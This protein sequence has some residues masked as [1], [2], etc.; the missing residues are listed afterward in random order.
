MCPGHKDEPR[1]Q[2]APCN[3]RGGGAGDGGEVADPIPCHN[4]QPARLRLQQHAEQRRKPRGSPSLETAL[5]HAE[6]A[7]ARDSEALRLYEEQI[8]H[9]LAQRR[10]LPEEQI[11]TA[12]RSGATVWVV[13]IAARPAASATQAYNP[14][15]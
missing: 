14:P 4:K 15:G 2:C 6:G 8:P 5:C 13:G 1:A 12:S 3:R 9:S 7:R 10:D 11:P